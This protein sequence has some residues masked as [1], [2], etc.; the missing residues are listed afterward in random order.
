MH[1]AVASLCDSSRSQLTPN[2]TV[3]VIEQ[4]Y[5]GSMKVVTPYNTIGWD[6]KV[7]MCRQAVELVN[8]I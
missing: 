6:H 7:L 8:K 4:L 2:A 1:H 3:T 5:E